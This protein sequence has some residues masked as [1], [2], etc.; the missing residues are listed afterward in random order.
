MVPN[1]ALWTKDELIC[2]WWISLAVFALFI[3][4]AAFISNSIFMERMTTNVFFL[5]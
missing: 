4:T 5:M 3:A 1:G 2:F